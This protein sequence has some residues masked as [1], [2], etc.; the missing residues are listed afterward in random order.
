M[1]NDLL[2]ITKRARMIGYQL[3]EVQGVSGY[4]LEM[5]AL[6]KLGEE[7]LT[8]MGYEVTNDNVKQLKQALINFFFFGKISGKLEEQNKNKKA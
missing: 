8:S 3:S 1:K 2:E 7:L 5:D 6:H 4:D